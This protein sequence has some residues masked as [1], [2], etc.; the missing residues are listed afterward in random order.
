MIF[1]KNFNMFI[2]DTPSEMIS[3]HHCKLELLW[4]H[5]KCI[6]Y[7]QEGKIPLGFDMR[8]PQTILPSRCL[9]LAVRAVCVCVLC[10]CMCA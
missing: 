10:S 4:V 5:T 6:S 3:D 9:P 7:A 8:L 2:G 1:Y